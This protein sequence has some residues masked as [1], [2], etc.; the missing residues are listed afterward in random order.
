MKNILYILFLLSTLVACDLSDNEVSKPISFHKIYDT[1]G[2]GDAFTTLD[3]QETSDEGFIILASK[4]LETSDFSGA[5]VLKVDKDGEY[6]SIQEIE[7]PYVHPVGKLLKIENQFH[8]V[9]MNETTLSSHLVS[10]NE[11]LSEI[12]TTSLSLNARPL[13]ANLDIAGD[14]I[15]LGYNSV[16]QVSTF[17]KHNAAG[18]LLQIQTYDIGAGDEVEVPIIEHFTSTGRKLPFFC[19][20]APDGFYYFNGYINYTLSLVFDNFT[21]DP[22]GIIQGSQDKKAISAANPQSI[23]LLSLSRFDEGVNFF[24]PQHIPSIPGTPIGADI[25][26]FEIKELVPDAK[27]V[28]KTIVSEQGPRDLYLSTTKSG[29]LVL[30]GYDVSTNQQT[31]IKYLGFSNPYAAGGFTTTTDGGLAICGSTFQAGRFARICMFKISA[32]EV[33]KL[34]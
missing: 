12:T 29:Q 5:V 9:V 34:F 8:F 16:D 17:S 7:A 2:F 18:N 11:S 4:Q 20:Q 22:I 32:E 6:V 15:V 19:G 31:G 14:I 3:I 23:L 24:T 13:S 26:G 10:V 33:Q 30:M 21:G 25:P 27:V 1:R 28:I